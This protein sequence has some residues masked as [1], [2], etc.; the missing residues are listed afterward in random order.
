[1]S[2]PCRDP[3]RDTPVWMKR[4]LGSAGSY[5]FLVGLGAAASPSAAAGW[6]GLDDP[7]LPFPWRISGFAWIALGAGLLAA[8]R[9]PVR[10]WPVVLAGFLKC[11]LVLPAVA[12]AVATGDLPGNAAWFALVDGLLCG[13]ALGVILWTAV[14]M[15]A[16]IR[17][18]RNAPFTLDEA[19]RGYF[20][21]TGESL[22][23]ASDRRPLLLVF[24]RHFGC[25]FTRRILREL[26]SLQ[27]AAQERG[28]ELVL[29]HMLQG[30]RETP[31]LHGHEDVARIADPRC[32][33]YRAFGLGKGG[34]LELFGPRVW[35]PG[36]VSLFK[37]C[38]VGHLAGD[39][40]QL[41]GAFLFH[42]GLILSA[43]RARSA[44][45]LP[46][47]ELLFS[48]KGIPEA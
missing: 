45:E 17:P 9:S 14:R 36:I 30:G 15:Q 48:Q 12:A 24:L 1:M 42:R 6:L 20:L 16:G 41:P 35:W 23:E 39:A 40:L 32:E 28:A 44:A 34:V 43:Q 3:F 37:G 46:D 10:H 4:L 27:H 38:G 21:G 29:V 22:A 5:H 2:A 31:H 19:A 7:G 26:E 18:S 8:S 13:I 47:P 25:T 33:L 11:L